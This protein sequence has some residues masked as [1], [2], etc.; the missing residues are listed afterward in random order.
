MMDSD[1]KERKF[2]NKADAEQGHG[3]MGKWGQ[4]TGGTGEGEAARLDQIKK[5]NA[6]AV[7]LFT[8]VI[9]NA[10]TVVVLHCNNTVTT[11]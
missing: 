10:I 6:A 11:L 7:A 2:V 4:E 1:M 9:A 5:D 8:K 3:G